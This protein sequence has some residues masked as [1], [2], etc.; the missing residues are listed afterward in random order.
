MPYA[1]PRH[2]PLLPALRDP[3]HV[4]DRL[5]FRQQLLTDSGDLTEAARMARRA[6]RMARWQ[7][8]VS[9]AATPPVAKPRVAPAVKRPP[10]DAVEALIAGVSLGRLMNEAQVER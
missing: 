4:V 8:Q 5:Q 1:I 3:V 6:S 9:K 10:V 7:A 2:S